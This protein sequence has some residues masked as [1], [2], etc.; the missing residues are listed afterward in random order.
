MMNNDDDG[1]CGDDE[2]EDVSGGDV[3]AV[4]RLCCTALLVARENESL[5]KIAT[6]G[7]L[8]EKIWKIRNYVYVKK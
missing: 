2:D 1:G 4:L 5:G 3:C 6:H 7:L 8:Q